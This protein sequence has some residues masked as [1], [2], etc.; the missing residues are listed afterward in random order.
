MVLSLCFKIWS[1]F[2]FEKYFGLNSLGYWSISNLRIFM[3]G[4]SVRACFTTS[5]HILSNP[6]VYFF[7]SGKMPRILDHVMGGGGGCGGACGCPC[8]G[9]KGGGRLSP[10]SD[11]WFGGSGEVSVCSP[12]SPSAFALFSFFHFIRLKK[13]KDLK[14][15][16]RLK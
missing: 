1:H 13:D 5:K 4:C 11:H 12:S 15:N 7:Y 8:R 14:L 3:Y 16:L 9:G 6:H 2:S 10:A